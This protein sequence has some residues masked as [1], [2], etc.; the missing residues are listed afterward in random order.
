MKLLTKQPQQLQ[1][2][3]CVCSRPMTPGKDITLCGS[4]IHLNVNVSVFMCYLPTGTLSTLMGGG[5]GV[6]GCEAVRCEAPAELSSAGA[7]NTAVSWGTVL[8]AWGA[9]T[10]IVPSRPYPP[11][12]YISLIFQYDSVSLRSHAGILVSGCTRLRALGLGEG[13]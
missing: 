8:M 11:C 6:F 9:L 5:G 13:G 12:T 7:Y 4:N 2:L 1:I 10:A 3:K